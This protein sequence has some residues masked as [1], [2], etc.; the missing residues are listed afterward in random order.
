[1]PARREVDTSRVVTF[2]RKT[3][4]HEV[5]DYEPGEHVTILGATRNGKTHLAYELLKETATPELPAVIFVMKPRDATVTKFSKANGY[6][7]VRDWPPSKIN[8]FAKKPSGYVLWP[9]ETAGDPELDDERHAR[10][11]QRAL[12]DNYKKGM[13]ITF[14]DEGY[15]LEQEY[16]LSKDMNRMWT[17]GG[18]MTSGLWVAT[19]RPA[20]IGRWAYQ[21]QHLFLSNDPDKDTQKRYGE[22]GAGVDADVVR[23]VTSR[24]KMYQWVYINRD[25]RAICIVDRR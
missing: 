21:A 18:S 5:W 10:I 20:F 16:N 6:R 8:V 17:K 12:R 9:K 2:D 25:Q 1:M 19:Q 4:I 3:F 13:K 14:A 22:I 24:L 7:I 15:S 23:E 11:F